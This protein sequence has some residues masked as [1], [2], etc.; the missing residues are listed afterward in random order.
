M[1]RRIVASKKGLTDEDTRPSGRSLMVCNPATPVPGEVF[2]IDFTK[3]LSDLQR[4]L[5]V[6]TKQVTVIWTVVNG[7]RVTGQPCGPYGTKRAR[8]GDSTTECHGAGK[9]PHFMHP[10]LVL[11]A[12]L[13]QAPTYLL[14]WP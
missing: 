12:N 13:G 2:L 4:P 14:Y 7:E 10:R 3:A 1:T 8:A 11:P 6:G 9:H 5:G